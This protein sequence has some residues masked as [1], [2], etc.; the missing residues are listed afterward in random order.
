MI[1]RWA[2][3][4]ALCLL[5]GAGAAQESCGG[6]YTLGRGESLSLIAE[7][8]YGDREKWTVIHEA[9]RAVIG[10]SPDYVQSGQTLTLPCLEGMQAG[11]ARTGA[12]PEEAALSETARS[13]PA[14]PETALP[15]TAVTRAATAP[16]T[17]PLGDQ[18]PPIPEISLL[19]ADDFAPFTDEAAPGG[20]LMIEIAAAALAEVV[21]GDVEIVWIN[22]RAAH[23]DPLLSEQR[24][25]LGLPWS[26]PD[27]EGDQS[28]ETLCREFL[29]SD[30]MFE[31]LSL[32]FTDV[33]RPLI[34]L[35]DADMAGHT[36]CRPL[37]LPTQ[38]LD[39]QGR[40]WV[41]GGLVTLVQPRSVAACFE[42]LQAGSVDAVALNEF[43]GRAAIR[44]LGLDGQVVVLDRRPLAVETLHAVV[45]KSHPRAED[46]IAAVNAGLRDIRRSGIFQQILDRHMALVWASL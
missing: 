26:R 5:A 44:D 18:V 3:A 17:E 15:D 11:D 33:D 41:S 42:M 28:G 31:M 37:G 36:L 45:S 25:D 21:T 19:V 46:Y 12:P 24:V 7:R 30:P 2:I 14:L 27:C 29:F 34:Y 32:L 43:T 1:D 10:D 40:N 39:G 20:G 23:L 22:D 9:N 6:S 4:G 38:D 16:G 13:D 35:S 8:L